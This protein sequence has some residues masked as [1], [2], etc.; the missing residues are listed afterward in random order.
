MET[1]CD[2]KCYIL[3]ETNMNSYLKYTMNPEK[4]TP[5]P[6]TAVPVN[7][8][9]VKIAFP[10]QTPVPVTAPVTVPVQ[11][12][13][14]VP[15]KQTP[16]HANPLFVPAEHDTLFWCYYIMTHGENKYALMTHKNT[17]IEKQLKIE[18]VNK[19]REHKAFLKPF[20]F[21]S[22]ANMENNLAYEDYIHIKT[23]MALCAIDKLNVIYIHNKTYF[24][25]SMNDSP[26]Y[27]IIKTGDHKYNKQSGFFSTSHIEPLISNL[28]K[29]EVLNKPIH[30]ASYY[31]VQDLIDIA[32]KLGIDTQSKITSK[33][34]TKNELYESIVQHFS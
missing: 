1:L 10:R 28:Y 12:P 34:K 22:L 5:N 7:K 33:K 15:V 16:I 8:E 23:I 20:K 25:L 11:V 9:P 17:I 3:N 32:N 30:A 14:Q 2:Y 31:K 19:M 24:Q 21:D 4:Q 6:V 26:E 13:V 27:Y 18:Y 29:L